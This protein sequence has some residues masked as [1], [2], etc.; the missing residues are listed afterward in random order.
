MQT[1]QK[2]EDKRAIADPL[3]R[4]EPALE[5]LPARVLRYSIGSWWEMATPQMKDEPPPPSG[6]SPF[7]ILGEQLPI[8]RV[9]LHESTKETSTTLL[10]DDDRTLATATAAAA[11]YSKAFGKVFKRR[12]TPFVEWGDSTDG[13]YWRLTLRVPNS[14]LSNVAKL[15]LLERRA[16]DELETIYPEFVGY[17]AVQYKL[18]K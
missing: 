9:V 16:Y 15:F 5:R 1:I 14:L 10:V 17:F 4:P 7:S 11:A 12:F 2:L 8:R 3:D 6:R 18:S 13:G